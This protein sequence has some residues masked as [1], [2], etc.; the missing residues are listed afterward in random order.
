MRI[1][2]IMEGCAPTAGND[3]I[4]RDNVKPYP[5]KRDPLSALGRFYHAQDRIPDAHRPLISLY[6]LFTESFEAAHLRN[7]KLLDEWAMNI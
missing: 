4:H 5:G 2:I 1:L 7:A 6:V 3:P